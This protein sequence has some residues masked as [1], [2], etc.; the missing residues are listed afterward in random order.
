[1]FGGCSARGRT[2]SNSC[3]CGWTVATRQTRDFFAEPGG[4]GGA[5]PT[6]ILDQIF[7]P[8]SKGRTAKGEDV[9]RTIL[10]YAGL[11]NHKEFGREDL[12]KAMKALYEECPC[13]FGKLPAALSD[14]KGT[15]L[16]EL[17][18]P[19]GTRLATNLRNAL[20]LTPVGAGLVA[21]FFLFELGAGVGVWVRLFRAC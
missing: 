4:A 1:V 17:R 12:R 14:F 6:A 15:T 3:P 2:L 8:G 21:C 7:P 20:A 18:K 5:H 10:A 13:L 9:C 19:Q 11:A 16:Q